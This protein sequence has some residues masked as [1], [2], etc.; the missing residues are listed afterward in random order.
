MYRPLP[1]LL[2][3]VALLSACNPR[4]EQV[5]L[6]PTAKSALKTTELAADSKLRLQ[7]LASQ[8]DLNNNA[9]FTTYAKR[10]TS[11][12]NSGWTRRID[13][14]GVS[15][16]HRQAG[17]AITPRHIV[18]ASHYKF[19]IGTSIT[20]HERSG[21]VHS[22]KIEKIISFRDKEEARSDI[23]V[24]LLNQPL[25]PTIKVYRLLPPREDYGHTLPGCP[26]IVTEQGRRA[27]VH[28]IRHA[29]TRYL[30]FMKNPDLPEGLYKPLIKGDS[31]HPSFLLVG[32]EPVLIETHSSGGGGRGP[33][34]SHPALFKALQET[35]A[36]LD[37]SYQIKTVPLD[38]ALA[39]APPPEKKPTPP[40]QTPRKHSPSSPSK[41]PHST[42][43]QP[44]LPR[45]RRVPTPTPRANPQPSDKPEE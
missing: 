12:W 3:S 42:P 38:P 39:P 43:R 31:G 34:Y 35:V 4:G 2:L 14:S 7:T 17:T 8:T 28:Q 33:F 1:F 5:S 6:G 18:F 26:V 41:K 15:W 10:S 45:V 44:R 25:P 19:K 16:S 40:N 36:Q 27:Y 11:Q 32:G 22:R 9:L 29:S 23:A 20:F 37:P 24:A 21:K 30:S 13:F